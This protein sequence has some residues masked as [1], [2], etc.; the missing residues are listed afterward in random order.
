MKK[1]Y[2]LLFQT[3]FLKIYILFS[4]HFISWNNVIFPFQYMQLNTF[5][6]MN[7]HQRMQFIL[8]VFLHFLA[9]WLFIGVQLFQSATYYIPAYIN[10]YTS[11]FCKQ[12]DILTLYSTFSLNAYLL[13]IT[14]WLYCIISGLPEPWCHIIIHIHLPDF[15]L[16]FLTYWEVNY[17]CSIY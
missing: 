11:G 16:W 14:T 17:L 15:S 5:S 9:Q 1:C 3:I 8:H 10:E 7:Y 2:H 12:S 13:L 6:C 4:F